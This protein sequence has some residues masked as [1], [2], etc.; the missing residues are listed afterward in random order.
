MSIGAGLSS[1]FML[2]EDYQFT[3]KYQNPNDPKNFQ[4]RN[5]N[6]HIMGVINLQV[7]YEQRLS[8]KMSIGLQPF[9][10][11]PMNDIGYSKVKLQSAGIAIN[12]NF[13]LNKSNKKKD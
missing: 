10:K 3:Y 9:V 12:V 7:A 11:I 2:K 8:S 6:Q 5:E 4:I 13:D 1:Y